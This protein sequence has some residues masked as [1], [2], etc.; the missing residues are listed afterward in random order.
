MNQHI[1]C[2][3]R[4]TTPFGVMAGRSMVTVTDGGQ[5]CAAIEFHVGPTPV[6]VVMAES[7]LHA[8]IEALAG[9][10]NELYR[11]R[12]LADLPNTAAE[13]EAAS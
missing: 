9:V 10:C 12:V 4:A 2:Q 11:A 1:T 5:D 8:F 13:L 6:M 3:A 7:H